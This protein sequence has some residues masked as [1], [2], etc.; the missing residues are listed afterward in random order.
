MAFDIN[1][2][3]PVGES[4]SSLKKKGFDIS[5]AKKVSA[6]GDKPKDP[7]LPGQ[8]LVDKL[9]SQRPSAVETLKEEV[10]TPFTGNI[11]QRLLKAGVT[12]LKTTAVPIERA[13]ATLAAPLLELQKAPEERKS[14]FEAG[15][16]GATGKRIAQLGDIPRQVGTP[17]FLSSFIGFATT[18]STANLATKGK[19]V[20]AAKAGERF[21]KSKLPKVMGKK[22]VLNQSKTMG[23]ILD[24]VYAG[25]S[26]EY[27]E[28]FK[29]IG[30]KPVSSELVSEAIQDLPTNIINKIS[31]SKLIRKNPDGTL[32]NDIKNI[33]QI[34]TMVRQSVPD[35][36]WSG[37]AI[38]TPD[39][40]NLEQ[41]YNKISSI[42]AEGNPQLVELNRR[43]AKFISDRKSIARIIYDADGN[44]VEKPLRSL[45]SKSGDQG[46]REIFESFANQFNDGKEVIKNVESFNRR[47]GAKKLLGQAAR[48]G[49]GFE[50]LR[51]AGQSILPQK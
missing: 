45:L 33:K 14:L 39:T 24:D 15:L 48:I 19:L 12:G 2:A 44:S 41:S 17:E 36:I 32:I 43:Y 25:L 9:I 49:V 1:T 31:R 6:N 13:E 40:A 10:E 23:K 46:K 16:E 37:R 20:G 34:R 50:V 51:R 8:E 4:D 3:K 27:D 22:F 35:R 26:K 7:L 21:I 38:G 28:V 18:L 47:Q 11:L 5:T 29:K 30:D 42:M